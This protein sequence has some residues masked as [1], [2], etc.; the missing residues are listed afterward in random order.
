MST[1]FKYA[2]YEAPPS[3]DWRKKGAV[4]DV[5]NQQQVSSNSDLSS[6]SW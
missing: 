1:G 6:C 2:E 5:K 3:I 4:T